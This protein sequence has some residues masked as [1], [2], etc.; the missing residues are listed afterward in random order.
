MVTFD[1]YGTVNFQPDAAHLLNNAT[2]GIAAPV[3]ISIQSSAGEPFV[4]RTRME[5]NDEFVVGAEHKFH[6]GF[7]V[8]A[9]YVDRRLKRIVE[10]M[11]GQSVEQ[12]T[13]LAYHHGFYEYTLGNPSDKLAVF[14]TPNE[15]TWMPTDPTNPNASAPAGCFDSNGNITPYTSGS[16]YNTFG[17]LQ[18][19]ACFP[20]VNMNPWTDSEGG[21][22]SGALFGGEFF[23]NGC[24]YCKPGLYPN[25]QRNYQAVEFEVDKS[26]SNNW[27]LFS[28]FRVG[29]L[30]GN[31]EGA[32]RNDNGQSDPGIT[33][34]FDLTDG[35]L[36]LLGQQLGI[37]PLNTDR[38]YVLN[39]LPAYTI[40]SGFAKN[41]VLGS[42]VTVLSG[43][44]LTTLAAQQI[45]GN[46][47]EVPLFGRGNLGRTPVTGTVSA[48][49]EYPFKFGEDQ[50]KQLKF[51]FDAFNIANTKRFYRSTQEVDLGF[52]IPNQDYSSH[53]PLNFVAP[54]T[55]RFSLLFTF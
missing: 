54:F 39:V 40:P 30:L 16:M 31:F 33:S 5:Y 6:G 22:L 2:G 42:G 48:H 24:P 49:L 10:D 29:R 9:R 45:Y 32:F 1:K 11:V 35:A 53:I 34:L 46:A 19:A 18:G 14:V 25:A 13:A 27:Q 21:T 52:G 43:V 44:P 23:P 20:A 50:N 15:I 26:F 38:K 28:N 4:P 3:S 36:G 17:V 37:G 12:L 8:S 55:A 51:S 41:L 7:F 47:G